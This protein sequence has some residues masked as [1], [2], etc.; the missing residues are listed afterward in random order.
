MSRTIEEQLSAFLD[1]ALPEAEEQLLLRRLERDEGHRETLLRYGLIGEALRGGNDVVSGLGLTRRIS[2]AVAAETPL[3]S[4]APAAPGRRGLLGAGMAAAVALVA[5]LA[6]NLNQNP[7]SGDVSQPAL[8]PVAQT[9]RYDAP[10]LSAPPR[11][12]LAPAR[13]T[14]YLV[15]HGDYSSGMSRQFMNSHVVNKHPE[16]LNASYQQGNLDD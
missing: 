15:S 13:L 5:I 12:Q 8:T 14:A 2:A 16:V 10:D 7:G 6:V 4:P 9:L 1:D 3:E 11:A